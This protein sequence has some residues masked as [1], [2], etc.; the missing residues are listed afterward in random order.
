MNKNITQNIY[1]KSN[2]LNRQHRQSDHI[3][4][5]VDMQHEMKSGM[6]HLPMLPTSN[7]IDKRKPD[8][9]HNLK[10]LH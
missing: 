5:P 10:L 8:Q 9:K 2:T 1:G 3:T 4:A 7:S 6:E